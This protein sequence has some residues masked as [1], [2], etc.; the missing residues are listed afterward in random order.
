MRMLCAIS[1]VILCVGSMFSC[2]SASAHVSEAPILEFLWA[3]DR[4][5]FREAAQTGKGVFGQGR[6][7]PNH[8]ALFG[9]F[10]SFGPRSG[11]VR[12]VFCSFRGQ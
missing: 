11:Q 12:Y 5:D 9:Q 7:I 2:T 6:Y 10:P 4:R 3:A 8:T 1:L